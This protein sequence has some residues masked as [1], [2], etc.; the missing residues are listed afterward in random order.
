[1][2]RQGSGRSATITA[3]PPPPIPVKAR[4]HRIPFPDQIFQGRVTAARDAK[5]G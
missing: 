5:K 4:I 3:I 2:K 1:M